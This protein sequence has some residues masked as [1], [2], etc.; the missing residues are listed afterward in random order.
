MGVPFPFVLIA[1]L[2]LAGL[3]D[4]V[5]KPAPTPADLG[6]AL[7]RL[8]APYRRALA[9]AGSGE[10]A[11]TASGVAELAEAW[12]SFDALR[13][14]QLARLTDGAK[15]RSDIAG[16]LREAGAVARVDPARARV[17]LE[18]TG[19]R[20]QELQARSGSGDGSAGS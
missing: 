5:R 16:L 9:A 17:L 7:A 3:V 18:Q 4:G 8:D 20:L 6:Q 11:R 1:V 13:G 19:A 12:S 2:L 15:M 10:S 14:A